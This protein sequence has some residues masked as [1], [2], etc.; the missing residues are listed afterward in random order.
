MANP[1]VLKQGLMKL[2][3]FIQDI[4]ELKNE[5]DENR[6]LLE[7]IAEHAYIMEAHLLN[8]YKKQIGD[9]DT[10]TEVIMDEIEPFPFSDGDE[11]KGPNIFD[12]KIS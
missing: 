8:L 12:I 11:D 6:E 1:Y 7:S 4:C 9:D 10:L 3:S 5:D 2:D